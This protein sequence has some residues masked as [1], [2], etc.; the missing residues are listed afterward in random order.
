MRIGISAPSAHAGSVYPQPEMRIAGTPPTPPTPLRIRVQG[1]SSDGPPPVPSG[2][3]QPVRYEILEM[4]MMGRKGGGCR[5]ENQDALLSR[6]M[7]HDGREALLCA[8]ADGVTRCPDGG[9]VAR[10]LVERHLASDP[11]FGDGEEAAPAL[12][13]YLRSVNT[14]FYKECA[15]EPEMIESA[16][17][18]SVGVIEQAT[19]HCFWVG[20]SPIF[21]AER[22]GDAFRCQQLSKPDLYGRLL[23]DGFGAHAPFELK[24]VRVDFAV[25][26]VLVLATDGVANSVEEFAY[27]IDH[28]G[29]TQRMIDAMEE[30]IRGQE[31]YDDASLVMIRRVA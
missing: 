19:A 16:C 7:M 13:R 14:L 27:W 1:S 31:F 25:G 30:E 17:T 28:F 21:F 9:G 3:S 26:D 12:E 22:A 8:V 20:D 2:R 15:A 11:V 29:P 5:E 23:V 24:R 4:T 18:L 6:R 10:Y